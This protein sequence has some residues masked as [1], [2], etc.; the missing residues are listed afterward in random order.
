MSR[1]S[2]ITPEKFDTFGEL[3]RFLRRKADLTQRELSIAVGYSESQISRL[4]KNER[5]P[6]EATLAARFVPALY[7]EDEPQW[8]ARLLELGSATHA[9]TSEA[10][11]LKPI[12]EAKPVPHNLPIQLTSFIGRENEI[13]EIW[14]HISQGRLVTLTGPGGCG[15]SR[16]ALQVAS[17]LLDVFPHGVWLIE[18]APL[19]DP[20][21]VPQTVATVLGVKEEPGRTLL[22]NLTDHLRGKK[23]LLILDN[24]EHLIQA[25]AQLSEALLHTCPDL[26]ILAAS[27]EL[28]GIAG[29]RS[30]S[31]PSL[32]TPDMHKTMTTD[33]MMN[34]EAVRLFIDRVVTVMPNFILTDA[35][36]SAVAQV[37]QRLD[38]IP[39]AIELAA[40]RVT[41]LRIEQ[42]A[43]RLDDAFHL[44]TSGSRTALPRHQTLRALIDWSYALL[45]DQERTLLNRSSVFAGGWTL[46]SAEAVGAGDSIKTSEVLDMLSQ[47]VKKS[48]VAAERKQ[49]TETRYGMLETIRQFALEKLTASGEVDLIRRRHAEYYLTLAEA[50]ALKLLPLSIWQDRM[51]SE[52]DNLW[53]AM[54]WSQSAAGSAELGLRLTEAVCGYLYWHG[55]RSEQLKKWLER[56]L[57]HADAEGVMYTHE[58]ANVLMLL[59]DWDGFEDYE[60]SQAWMMQSLSIFQKLGDLSASA[61]AIHRL[62]WLAREHGDTATARLRLEESVKLYR[63]LENKGELTGPL[64]TLGEVAVMQEDAVLATTLLEEAL[65]LSRG[66]GN[67]LPIGWALN[68]LGHAAQ[69]QGEYERAAQLH[70]E[71]LIPFDQ[72]GPRHVG[73]VWAH[74]GLG[75]TALAQGDATLAT[76]HFVQA[77]VLSRDLGDRAGMAWCLAGLAGVAALNEEPERAAWLWGAAEA[78]RQS[79]GAREA[80]ASHA[81]HERLQADVRKQLGEETFNAKWAEGQSASVEQAIAEVTR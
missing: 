50:G 48:L 73:I 80:P 62:G 19:A 77:L 61:D 27:R 58:R 35:N 6:E 1:S 41:T 23:V 2:T 38:G 34:Y 47:L 9:N 30:F 7:I 44:L 17:G 33:A 40:A 14:Q 39:L 36:A 67:P 70:K 65:S 3:L 68:H 29:E 56:A 13:I 8:I 43:A 49:G 18:L 54:T 15:K 72:I 78:F 37:C 32:S 76:T 51:D 71:S 31:V 75:E 79:I 66:L 60:T 45:S 20:A 21:L 10:D 59:A 12:A 52:Q 55:S 24:C 69:I 64:I 5:A 28:L 25:S 11:A 63:E 4:E 53:A 81:T 46:E 74:Q 26:C 57:A 16:L 22:S 42:I